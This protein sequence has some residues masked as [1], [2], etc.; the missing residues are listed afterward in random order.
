MNLFAGSHTKSNST[1][2]L[3]FLETVFVAVKDGFK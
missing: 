1:E 3:V 2:Y